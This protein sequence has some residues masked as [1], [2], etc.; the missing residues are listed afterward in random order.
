MCVLEQ[1][2]FSL[3]NPVPLLCDIPLMQRFCRIRR[4]PLYLK[5]R[6]PP[7]NCILILNINFASIRLSFNFIFYAFLYFYLLFRMYCSQN[8]NVTDK[9]SSNFG[10]GVCQN[11]YSPGQIYSLYN[12]FGMTSPTEPFVYTLKV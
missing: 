4:D 5:R 7:K 9:C 2:S 12:N 6:L 3:K 10:I 8:S 1:K 11:Y